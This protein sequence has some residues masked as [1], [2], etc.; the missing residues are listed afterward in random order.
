M[1]P[2]YKD[3][4]Q[5]QLFQRKYISNVVIIYIV[6]TNLTIYMYA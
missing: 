2:Q 5:T 1:K 3:K 4:E 6:P